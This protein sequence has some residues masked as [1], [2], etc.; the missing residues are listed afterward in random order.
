MDALETFETLRSDEVIARWVAKVDAVLSPGLARYLTTD[1]K[2][3]QAKA[4]KDSVWGMV[5][6]E[7]QEVVVLDSPPL[8]RLR[9]IRQLGVSYLTYPTAGYSR[10]EHTIG[11]MH[12]AE[13]MLRAVVRRTA[14]ELREG[15]EAALPTVRLAA[16]LHDVGHLPLSHL[17]ERYYSEQE[18]VDEN[19]RLEVSGFRDQVA[20][21]LPAPRPSLSECLS[22]AIILSPAFHNLLTTIAH[23]APEDVA[24]AALS[25]VG[26][27]PS[28]RQAFVMQLVTNAIDADKLDYMFRDSLATGVPIGVDLQRLLYKLFCVDVSGPSVPSRLAEIFGAGER[29]IVLSTDLAGHQLAYDLAAARS[30]LFERIYFHH[31]TRAAER[32]VL[33]LLSRLNPDPVTLLAHDDAYFSPGG[34]NSAEPEVLLLAERRLPRR[35]FSMSRQYLLPSATIEGGRADLPAEI[36]D[37]WEELLEDLKDAE[38]RAKLHTGNRD[39]G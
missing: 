36:A 28:A 9:R 11:A 19:G 2:P 1:P 4:V 27:P 32:A 33:R 6:L 39:R 25:I 17:S 14:H 12:Q 31:K 8:Q 20:L 5:D 34:P 30:I 26:R 29:T 38:Q 10:F 23:Y 24:S 13:R 37:G 7:Q 15:I 16:L 18:M 22:L 3:R 35:I 21:L